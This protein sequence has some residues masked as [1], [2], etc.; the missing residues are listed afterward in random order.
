MTSQL[1]TFDFQL[2]PPLCDE[3]RFMLLCPVA[4][5]PHGCGLYL[6]PAQNNGRAVLAARS[7]KRHGLYRASKPEPR[8]RAVL[9][10]RPEKRCGLY[11]Q[12]GQKRVIAHHEVFL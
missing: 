9:A 1:S 7:E 11:L 5:A 12:P 3:R 2:Q 6:Q 8:V 4:F 10:A